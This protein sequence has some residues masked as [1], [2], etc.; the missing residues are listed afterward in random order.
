[1]DLIAR[2]RARAFAVVADDPG[3]AEHSELLEELTLRFAASID[4][5]FRS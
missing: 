3:L 1:V 4:W 2:A 5:L